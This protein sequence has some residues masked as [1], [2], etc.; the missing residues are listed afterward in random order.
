MRHIQRLRTYT[1]SLLS[2]GRTN[3]GMFT[4]FL[5]MLLECFS[6]M[7]CLIN[8]EME[9]LNLIEGVWVGMVVI[10]VGFFVLF[11]WNFQQPNGDLGCFML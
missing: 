10:E 4:C 1:L 7:L 11:S 3:N 6:M 9:I 8:Q 5:I 2:S